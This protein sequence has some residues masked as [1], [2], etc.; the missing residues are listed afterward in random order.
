MV[1]KKILVLGGSKDQLPIIHLAKELGH[2]IV[3][4]DKNTNCLARE[5][6]DYFLPISINDIEQ[7]TRHA[8][9][10]KVDA[11]CSMITEAG[12]VAMYQVCNKLKLPNTYTE[13]S[14]EATLSKIK[15]RQIL[16]NYDLNNISYCSPKT[17]D[18]LRTFSNEMNHSI[19]LKSSNT[20]GQ[21]GL[22]LIQNE[23][24]LSSVLNKININNE[25]IAERF[26]PGDEINC[27]F[28]VYEGKVKDCIISDRIKDDKAFGIVKRHSFPSKYTSS[29]QNIL[30][31]YCQKLSDVLEIENGIVFPQFIISDTD[32]KPYLLELGVRIPGGIMDQLTQYST[33]LDLVQFMLDISLGSLKDYSAYKTKKKYDYVLVTFI[34]AN[35][36]PLK[37][38]KIHSI[39]VPS[40]KFSQIKSEDFFTQTYPNIEIF[41]LVDGGSRFYYYISV[42]STFEEAHQTSEKFYDEL[43]FYL[44]DKKSAKK[45]NFDFNSYFNQK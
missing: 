38:G 24:Q 43:D 1:R 13:K 22:Y 3:V 28:S 23:K 18:Q 8:D 45:S 17:I 36:G 26:I 35:P 15:M 5:V 14:A 6:A 37:T 34:N 30:L 41:P 7:L 27:V 2:I 20:G 42:G 32:K 19:V 4:A 39:H 44:V 9:K 25:I 33:G 29:H 11:I 40:K 12:V 10:L 16:Q 21:R 31:D